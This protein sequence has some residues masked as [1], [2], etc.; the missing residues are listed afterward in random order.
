MPYLSEHLGS[1]VAELNYS[2]LPESITNKAKLCLLDATGCLAAAHQ[3]PLASIVENYIAGICASTEL[4]PSSISIPVDPATRAGAYALLINA[5]DYD[6]IYWKGHPGATVNATA[7]SMA[8]TIELSGSDVILAIVAGYEVSGRVAMSLGHSAPRKTVHGHGTWQIFG[9]AAAAAKLLNLDAWQTAH[10]L[11]IAA[12]NA[13]VPSVMKTVYGDQPSLAKNNFGSAAQAG[14]TAAYLARAGMEGP[15]DV[16]EG[17]TGFWRMA[18]AEKCD[19]T[20][21]SRRF[22]EPYEINDVGFKAFSCCRIIQACA[23]AARAAMNDADVADEDAIDLIVAA[24]PE[25]ACR[26]PFSIER[27]MTMSA[28]QFSV[29]YAIVATILRMLFGMEY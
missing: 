23:E 21:L 16:F 13:P 10:A 9:A 18:G 27:P 29:P 19:S 1:L 5:L 17:D 15:L 22:G 3:S 14:V 20:R 12:A 11:A 4:Q 8:L 24:V 26:E 7:L 6:D 28:A 25:I 2:D